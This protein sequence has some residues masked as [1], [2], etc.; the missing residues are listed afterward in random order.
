MSSI[1]KVDTIQNQSGANIISESAN[2][3]T[4]G[5]SGD[6]VTIPSG[7]TLGGAGTFD[8]TSG[9]VTLNDTMKNTP[10]FEAYRS[11]DQTPSNNTLTKIQFNT[12]IYDTDGNYDNSTNYRFTPTTAGKYFV[13]GSMRGDAESATD[14]EFIR[15]DI[16][17][18]GST[19]KN[20]AIEFGAT[21]DIDNASLT[22]TAV[23]DMNGSTDY[24]EIFGMLR[25]SVQPT[26]NGDGNKPTTFG[27]YR[28][29][30]A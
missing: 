1:I 13:Y 15:L 17:K 23:V 5:A 29:I 9:S 19:Y 30:G 7:A 22:I 6:T 25:S 8:L 21:N 11:S 14:L 2:T 28:I 27:A 20:T 3:I 16:Y 18:N 24:L 4:V 12:E 10:A 26:I